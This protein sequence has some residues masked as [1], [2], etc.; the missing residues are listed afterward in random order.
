MYRNNSPKQY[1][2]QNFGGKNTLFL[3]VNVFYS[4]EVKKLN[5]SKNNN[6]K[7]NIAKFYCVLTAYLINYI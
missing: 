2:F 7:L 4:Y 3:N 5:S 1:K 6:N